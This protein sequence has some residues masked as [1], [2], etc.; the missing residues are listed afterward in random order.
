MAGHGDVDV[1]KLCPSLMRGIAPPKE[2][3]TPFL[4]AADGRRLGATSEVF[5]TATLP[6]PLPS[7]V[8][9]VPSGLGSTSNDERRLFSPGADALAVTLFCL[10]RC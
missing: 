6:W 10:N 4:P 7:V 3:T 8:S 5:P 1:R 2:T 9:T